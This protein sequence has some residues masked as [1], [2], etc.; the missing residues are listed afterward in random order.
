[1]GARNIKSEG[2]STQ[3]KAMGKNDS[4]RVVRTD[5]KGKEVHGL[6]PGT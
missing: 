3:V 1:M 4:K 5:E 2:I 6:S